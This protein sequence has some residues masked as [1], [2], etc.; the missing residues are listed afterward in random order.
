MIKITYSEQLEQFIVLDNKSKTI[1][2]TFK[3]T[4]L[5]R[6]SS[7]KYYEVDCKEVDKF[8][9]VWNYKPIFERREITKNEQILRLIKRGFR[10]IFSKTKRKAN[11]QISANAQR[12]SSTNNGSVWAGYY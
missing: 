6:I 12:G 8:L 2:C 4:L 3:N 11:A 1:Q 10:Q 7:N 5:S 9:K